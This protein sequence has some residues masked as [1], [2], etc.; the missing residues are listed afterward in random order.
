MSH[1]A[2]RRRVRVAQVLLLAIMVAGT[3]Y[4]ADAVVG[5]GL[6]SSPYR[7]TV[8]MS[9]AGGLHARSTVNYRG[10]KVGT[11]R[12]VR[13]SSGGVTAEIE[14][15]EDVRVPKDSAFQVRNLSA[16]GE[17]Y[18]NIEPRTDRGPW[19]EDG[20]HIDASRTSL[21]MPMPQVL[22]DVQSLMKRIDVKDLETIATE[23]D[24]AFGDGSANLRGL[25]TEMEETL[26]LLVDLEPMLTR[27]L[28][29][30]ETPLTTGV[31]KQGELRR[32]AR[33]MKLITGELRSA[34][35]ALRRLVENG[36][37][38]VTDVHELWKQ[39]APLLSDLIEAG[40]PLAR[41]SERHVPGLQHWLDWL[42]GQLDAMAGST[43]DG[44]GRVLLVPKLLDNCDFGVD[45][46]DPHEL[47]RR[48]ANTE[49]RCTTR[50]PK[51]QQRGSQNVPRP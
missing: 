36:T 51:V 35:P 31:E 10:Q 33:N 17:Q 18:L 2:V 9:G 44:S 27:M 45:R 3:V 32:I 28:E 40:K 4:V 26:D 42:P 46:R 19:L 30:A 8:E 24:H 16:I 15:E 38:T 23:T 1:A 12:E 37:A 22:A 20:G 48:P 39:S 5:G 47:G 7:V 34:N 50:E 29:R 13:L 41:M 49:A 14:L 25:T 6:F 11:V 43:R 21:P